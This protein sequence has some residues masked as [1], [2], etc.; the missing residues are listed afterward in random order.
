MA[1][2]DGV[3]ARALYRGPRPQEDVSSAGTLRATQAEPAQ[4]LSTGLQYSQ[5]TPSLTRPESQGPSRSPREHPVPGR[6]GLGCP[7][8]ASSSMCPGRHPRQHGASP[9]G[10][11]CVKLPAPQGKI[12]GGQASR[13]PRCDC[14]ERGWAASAHAC[15]W[16][17][18]LVSSL[19]FRSQVIRLMDSW[20]SAWG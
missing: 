15:S 14:S 10:G 19:P 17:C 8:V 1:L 4:L 6:G 20:K 9:L 12:P 7:V 2:E 18:V 16:L 3:H 5:L 13:R 11:N